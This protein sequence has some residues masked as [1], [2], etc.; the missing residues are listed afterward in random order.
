MPP[1]TECDDGTVSVTL[2]FADLAAL[3]RYFEA[4]LQH[5]ETRAENARLAELVEDQLRRI[6]TL[7]AEAESMDGRIAELEE[8]LETAGTP[9]APSRELAPASAAR[10]ENRHVQA[11]R[12]L[13]VTREPALKPPLTGGPAS[14]VRRD[15]PFTID[16]DLMVLEAG[17][18][19]DQA[20]GA[21]AFSLGRSVSSVLRRHREILAT[22][23][24]EM[25]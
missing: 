7:K 21:V 23:E 15:T 10:P 6:E 8:R 25:R 20:L 19:G 2:G 9:A 5:A 16:E 12:G 14:N 24:A 11:R 1:I 22:T 4:S 17:E 3:R 13:P 18:K